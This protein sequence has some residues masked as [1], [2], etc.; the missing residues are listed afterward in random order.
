MIP[1]NSTTLS[2]LTKLEQLI[3]SSTRVPVVNK[4]MVDEEELLD[5]LD[6]LRNTLPA[7][8]EEAKQI[9]AYKNNVIS[10]A[11]KYAEKIV[12]E[13]QDKAKETID[14]T[15]II[16]NAKIE[17]DN[18]RNQIIKELSMQQQDAD[19]YSEEVLTALEGK[20]NRALTAVQN[21]R[22]QLSRPNRPE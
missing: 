8:M 19:K 7:E 20:L 15:E 10:S 4:I 21:G 17:A 11:K 16:K 12:T 2:L 6:S 9:V 1:I 14:E 22:S 3:I 5:I 13:S 18:I